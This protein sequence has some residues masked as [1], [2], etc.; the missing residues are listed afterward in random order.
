MKLQGICRP[1]DA[2]RAVE[3][4]FT[5]I[6][7]RIKYFENHKDCIF[8][9]HFNPSIVKADKEMEKLFSGEQPRRTPAGHKVNVSP[10]EFK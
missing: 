8:V 2:V 7:V 9:V 1:E 4:G 3:A 6:W 10:A 5:T